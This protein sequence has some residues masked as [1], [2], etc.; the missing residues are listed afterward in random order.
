[1]TINVGGILVPGGNRNSD[2]CLSLV[3]ILC[4]SIVQGMLGAVFMFSSV[5]STGLSENGGGVQRPGRC[6]HH[7]SRGGLPQHDRLQKSKAYSMCVCY[8]SGLY[9]G[10]IIHCRQWPIDRL[11]TAH[12]SVLVCTYHTQLSGCHPETSSLSPLG[13]SSYHCTVPPLVW[14]TS[15]LQCFNKFSIPSVRV[16]AVKGPFSVKS[17]YLVPMVPHF[18]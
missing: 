3:R 12:W 6:G 15:A 18:Q 9:E 11:L 7:W 16:W 1:M 13:P 10:R 5:S 4:S 17:N 8:M 2:W 14:Q